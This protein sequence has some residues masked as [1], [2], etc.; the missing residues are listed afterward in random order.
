MER[1]QEIA[2]LVNVLH[3]IA[4]AA[5][6]SSWIKT[7][8]EAV[9]FCVVQYNKVLARL[10]ELEPNIASIYG[11]LAEDT[12]PE[13]VRMAAHDLAAYFEDEPG[14]RARGHHQGRRHCRPRGVAFAW[15]PTWRRCS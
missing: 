14:V 13:V 7:E 3:R 2:K 12:S 6:F 4:R 11:Q 5:S 10:K 9:K 8:A 1:E 15:S